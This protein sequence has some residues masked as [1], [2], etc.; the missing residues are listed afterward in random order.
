MRRAHEEL[1]V[2]YRCDCSFG[3]GGG[4]GGG[5]RGGGY[6]VLVAAAAVSG[7]STRRLVDL[8]SIPSDQLFSWTV[9]V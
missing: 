2:S 5:V 7:A 1:A 6:V 9:C 8:L 4:G 3:S